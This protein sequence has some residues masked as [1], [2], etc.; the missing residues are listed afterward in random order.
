MEE[1]NISAEVDIDKSRIPELSMNVVLKL[2]QRQCI[3]V[4]YQSPLPCPSYFVNHL[5]KGYAKNNVIYKT[6]MEKLMENLKIGKH[7]KNEIRTKVNIS[8]P[9]DKL[10]RKR[11]QIVKRSPH[12][13]SPHESKM[14]SVPNQKR[15]HDKTEANIYEKVCEL[16]FYSIEKVEDMG[17]PLLYNVMYIEARLHLQL[18]LRFLVRFLVLPFN[19]CKRVN[20]SRMFG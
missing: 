7:G 13:T 3:K 17:V 11:R 19:A 15:H 14:S 10:V 18:S 16:L 6:N 1:L 5:F 12:L 20:L 4:N 2:L 9:E 8:Q